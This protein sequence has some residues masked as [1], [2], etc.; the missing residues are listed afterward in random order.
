MIK[1]DSFARIEA[2]FNHDIP[3]RVPKYEISIELQEFNPLID[4]QNAPMALLFLT[5]GMLNFFHKIPSLFHFI[6]RIIKHP[7]I[8]QPIGSIG[9][10]IG[11]KLHRQF[12]YD[13]FPYIS[14]IPLIFTEDIFRDFHTEEKKKLIT[15]R[16]GRLV[17]KSSAEGAHARYGFME[18][19]SDWDRYMQFDPDHPGNYFLVESAVR[20]SKKLDIVPIFTVFGGAGFEELCGMFGFEKLF[21]LLFTDK[22]FI[23]C[24]V[25]D[26]NDYA[27][28]VAE[29]ILQ[30]GGKYILF[31]SDLG[32]TSRSLIS[33]KMFRDF[34]KPGMKKFCRRVHHLGGRTLFHSCGNLVKLMP[35]LI[36]TGI[37]ALHPIERTAGNDIV[38]FKKQYGKNLVL[39]G[40]VPIPL[41]THG[42]PKEVVTYVKYLLKNISVDGGH[43]LSSSHSI[44]QWCQVKNFY[45]YHKAIDTYGRYPITIN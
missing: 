5:P 36:A 30:R 3:D 41:L 6:K 10:R 23:R 15:H 12:N 35:D 11:S 1:T 2:V 21:R 42:T 18:S 44:T 39:V 33:P 20:A 29:G 27:I 22:N 8:L 28:A 19:P 25:Q 13:I 26:M 14:G 38:E 32:Y 4:G 40:N 45:A 9:V 34:F 37:D 7:R 43:I 24:A 16:S 17:W 31:T